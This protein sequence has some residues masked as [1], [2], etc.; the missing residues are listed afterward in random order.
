MKRIFKA[1]LEDI[2]ISYKIFL[3]VAVLIGSMVVLLDKF[4]PIAKIFGIPCPGCGMSRAVFLMLNGRISESIAMHPVL[5]LLIIFII[6]AGIRKYIIN[7]AIK[8][9]Y[10]YAVV[11]SI[12]MISVYIYRMHKYFPNVEPMIFYEENI[13]GNV[14]E[15]ID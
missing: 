6:Y 12:I 1:I 11:F 9:Y 5:P 14:I 8:D 2:K 15:K 13:L 4:C 3:I 10:R 7:R